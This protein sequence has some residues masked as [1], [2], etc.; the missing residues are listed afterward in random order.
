MKVLE[1]REVVGVAMMY[2]TGLGPHKNPF[3]GK[4]L[5]RGVETDQVITEGANK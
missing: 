3:E 4:R 1:G 5:N 2:R